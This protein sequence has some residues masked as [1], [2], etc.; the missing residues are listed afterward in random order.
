MIGSLNIGGTER[1]LVRILPE[2]KKH[3]YEVS[4]F[5]LREKGDLSK[6][7]EQEGIEVSTPYF[8]KFVLDLPVVLKKVIMLFVMAVAFVRRIM[9]KRPEIVHF[10]LPESYLV[11]GVLSLPFR[12]TLRI[13]SRRSQNKYQNRYPLLARTEKWLHGN[14][15]AILGNSKLVCAELLTEGV[16]EARI[17]LIYNG[18]DMRPYR[19]AQAQPKD[20]RK[21]LGLEENT[22]VISIVA[23]L[24]P[25]KGH[26][27]LLDALSLI[28]S[29]LPQPWSLLCIGKDSGI[30]QSLKEKTAALQLQENV[31]WLGQRRDVHSLL[32]ISDIG[33][34][35]SHEEGLANAIIEGM[36]A[37]L[38]MVATD[39]GGARESILDGQTGFIVPPAMPEDLGKAILA[40]AADEGLRTKMGQAGQRY[41]CEKFSLDSCV[42]QYVGLYRGLV[43]TPHLSVSDILIS[44]PQGLSK[45]CAE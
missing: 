25:Y 19:S 17:G 1:H 12:N 23:N 30:L 7:L 37:G 24:I 18:V 8:S 11:G 15:D 39:V 45:T 36:M 2:I 35:S 38:P 4:V 34:L 13:M 29:K 27:D 28:C 14:M 33:V 9:T 31:I 42:G 43:A 41:A 20:L 26:D 44:L 21:S 40:L 10:F 6:V 16:P 5:A 32:Q 22:L 3:G